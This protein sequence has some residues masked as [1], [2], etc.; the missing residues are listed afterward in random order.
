MVAKLSPFLAN[1]VGHNTTVP[2]RCKTYGHRRRAKLRETVRRHHLSLLKCGATPCKLSPAKVC[3]RSGEPAARRHIKMGTKSLSE[4]NA[5]NA[6]Y[7]SPLNHNEEIRRCRY[8]RCMTHRLGRSKTGAG[9]S[10]KA[11][12]RGWPAALLLVQR[13]NLIVVL[14]PRPLVPRNAFESKAVTIGR[15]QPCMQR[16]ATN[17]TDDK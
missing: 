2:V 10:Q 1:A 5:A 6:S 12:L 8:G 13:T 7:R 15:R 9:A 16:K 11:R 17:E 14:D 4:K 3:G